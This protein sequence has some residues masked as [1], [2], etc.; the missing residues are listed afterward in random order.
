MIEYSNLLLLL[1]V[2]GSTCYVYYRLK[3]V[4]YLISIIME[5]EILDQLTNLERDVDSANI[6]PKRGRKTKA[7]TKINEL[8]DNNI[9]EKRERL[10]ACVLSGNSEM[11]IGK[12]YTKQQIDEIDCTNVNT[13]LNRYES[14]LSAQMTKSLAKNVRN[15][16]LNKACSLLGVAN[17]Q[18]LSADLESN[19]F[20]TTA[21]QR[22]TCDLY[23]RFSILLAPVSVGIITGKHYAKNS[24]TKLNDRSVVY[25][26]VDRPSCCSFLSSL[27]TLLLCGQSLLF[28]VDT[29]CYRTEAYCYGVKTYYSQQ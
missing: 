24:G 13:L 3:K 19:P 5:S 16:Y 22:F 8:E 4:F 2:F 1:T 25:I 15:L 11:Y 18:E 10:V 14:I 26:A 9:R 20:L 27:I 28:K 12:K 23:Y 21:L 7:D 29:Y 6:K 17:Q